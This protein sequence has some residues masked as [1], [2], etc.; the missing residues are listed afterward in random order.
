[1]PVAK[2]TKSADIRNPLE[3]TVEFLK[4]LEK[5]NT[6][7]WFNENRDY[8]EASWLFPAQELVLNLGEELRTISPHIVAL[9]KIDQTIFRIYRDVRFSKNKQPF[10]THLGLFFWEAGRNKNESAGYYFH[11][12]RSLL[13]LAAGTYIFPKDILLKYRKVVS[14]PKKAA[15]LL[16]LHK[17]LEKKGYKIGG[18]NLKK[19][20][21]GYQSETA[22]EALL[23]TG[24][25]VFLELKP[26]PADIFKDTEKFAMSHYKKMQ[27]MFQWLVD[28]LY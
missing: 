2:N 15:E 24:M 22:T 18:K 26:V 17:S 7:T 1:M 12:E 27:P 19:I 6:K 28:N 14:D 20:P 13:I 10:K 4:K 23:F 9:P 8:Y 11:I 21:R 5:N 3:Y 25:D 16:K